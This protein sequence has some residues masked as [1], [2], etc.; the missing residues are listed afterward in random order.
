MTLIDLIKIFQ[1][2]SK[3]IYGSWRLVLED[4]LKIL[5]DVFRSI[6]RL[7]KIL[8]DSFNTVMDL[9][10]GLKGP[11]VRHAWKS[12]EKQGK[13]GGF[14]PMYTKQAKEYNLFPYHEV[15]SIISFSVVSIHRSELASTNITIR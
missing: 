4:F 6:A 15:G 7:S 13:S 12:K 2:F 5:W 14:S 8:E 3:F 10:E 11:F 1:D 9:Y